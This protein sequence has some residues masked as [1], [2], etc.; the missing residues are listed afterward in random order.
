M[1]GIRIIGIIE[2]L[3]FFE[4]KNCGERHEIFGKSDLDAVSGAAGIPVLAKLP[5]D[6]SVAEFCDK[7]EVEA[8]SDDEFEKAVGA[9]IL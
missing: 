9:I 6:P 4:C 7:G 5:I 8:L 3:S 1:M 2:N